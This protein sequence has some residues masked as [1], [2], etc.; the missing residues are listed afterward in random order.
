MFFVRFVFQQLQR[1]RA[2]IPLD[3]YEM[4]IELSE[5]KESQFTRNDAENDKQNERINTTL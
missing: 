1:A 2:N 4:K 5:K 3:A